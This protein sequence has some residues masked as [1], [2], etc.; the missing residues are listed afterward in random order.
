VARI[1]Q[2]IR[3]RNG[4]D[5]ITLDVLEEA[6]DAHILIAL[7]RKYTPELFE[8]IIGMKKIS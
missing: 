8:R 7:Q 2:S 4:E 3:I 6:L 5:R 1:S